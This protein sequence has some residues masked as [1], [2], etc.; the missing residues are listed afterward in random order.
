MRKYYKFFN[1]QRVDNGKWYEGCF[2]V[3]IV[4][5]ISSKLMIFPL[6]GV[7]PFARLTDQMRPLR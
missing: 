7:Q 1:T 3:P 2:F 4:L 5:N 6:K